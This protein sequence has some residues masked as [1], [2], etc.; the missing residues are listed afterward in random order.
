MKRRIVLAIAALVLTVIALASC[1]IPGM[2]TGQTGQTEKGYTRLVYDESNLKAED[3]GVIRSSI[4]NFNNKITVVTVDESAIDGEIVFGDTNRAI[5][6]KAKSKMQAQFEKDGAECG[7]IIY[8]EGRNVAVYWTD[9]DMKD[10]V[11]SVFLNKC[12]DDDKLKLSEG[13]YYIQGYTTK[14]YSQEKYW[15]LL[16]SEGCSE[17]VIAAFKSI[18]SFYD[19]TSICEWMANLWDD[20]IGGFYY[21]NSARD[22]EPFLPDLESTNQLTSWIVNNNATGGLSRNIFLPNEMKMKIVNF[23]KEMQDPSSGYF[24]HPQWPQGIE[25]LNTDRYGRDLSWATSLI[26]SLYVDT[27][28]DGVAEK[29]Y[30]TYC[31]PSGDKCEKHTKN[32]GKCDYSTAATSASSSGI[33][34][35]CASSSTAITAGLREDVVG[36]A[37]KV[38]RNNTDVIA[39][40]SVSSKPVYTSSAAFTQWLWDYNGSLEEIMYGKNTSGNAHNLN[41]LQSE[42]IGKGFGD[43]M[44]AWL[45]DVQQQIWDY[46][47]AAGETPT[48]VWQTTYDKRLV[49]AILKYMPFYN[50]SKCGKKIELDT[51]LAMVRSCTVVI[52]L[53]PDPTWALNDMMNLWGS[54]N[55]IISNVKKYYGQ[56]GVDK[57]YEIT[58]ENLVFRIENCM[59]RIEPYKLSDGTFAYTQSRKS[60]TQIYGVPISLGLEE[61]DVNGN[62]LVCTMYRGIF[63]ATGYT[64]VPI[65]TEVDGQNF[66]RIIENLEPLE[67][68]PI[69]I[70]KDL[71]FEDG[72]VP[73]S[74]TLKS[75]TQDYAIEVLPDPKDVS[76]SALY[77]RSGIDANG[78]NGDYL[79]VTP[80]GTGGNCAIAEFRMYLM[81]TCSKSNQ[82]FQIKLGECYMMTLGRDK[83]GIVH[84][85]E[86]TGT[87]SSAIAR[88]LYT[89]K[90]KG[91]FKIRVE[92]Y[93][94]ESTDSG[95][96]EIKLFVDD[97]LVAES[98]NY[99]NKHEV[100]KGFNFYYKEVRFYSTMSNF[101]EVY[102]DD[103]FFNMENKMYE[104]GSDDIS[105]SRG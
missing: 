16:E 67:K 96:P 13:I 89:F 76:N 24:F 34:I 7:F 31:A 74:V 73:A 50:S 45:D 72:E 61:G 95:V 19:G 17:E 78:K 12:V 65:C 52:E 70:G 98:K 33:A 35:A 28:G 40:A 2:Q 3:L 92:M 47:V 41:A 68:T 82:L 104:A 22:N 84:I 26:G 59:A 49:W 91:W 85:G 32:G 77:F 8:V 10:T 55:N 23:A 102:I 53:E 81:D 60:P 36:A 62:G 15:L 88:E 90:D 79:Y 57:I 93:S 63:E 46:Q 105:D 37:A 97:E 5:T 14:E 66:L 69:P 9:E 30:P 44:V 6:K 101:T 48:G 18:N 38:R 80:G 43:E 25:R 75:N 39:A 11:L 58:R 20:D 100:G 21:S 56:D 71:D 94:D 51:A 64:T 27:D 42:I 103:C 99:Y 86:R 29:Q 4:F 83:S 54:I 87:G 1:Q